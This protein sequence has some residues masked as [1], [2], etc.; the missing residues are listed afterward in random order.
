MKQAYYI[1]FITIVIVLLCIF[2]QLLTEVNAFYIPFIKHISINF[3]YSICCL[4]AYNSKIELRF[5]S[6]H[7]YFFVFRFLYFLYIAHMANFCWSW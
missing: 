5:F 3:F 4:F 1:V 2:D 6:P 7:S